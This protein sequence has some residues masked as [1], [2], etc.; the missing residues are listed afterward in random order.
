MLK[1][2]VIASNITNL[3]DARYFAARGVDYLLFDLS[4]IGINEVMAIAE[5]VEG[6]QILVSLSE[7]NAHLVD[8]VI[9]RISP[10]AIGTAEASVLDK[11]LTYAADRKVFFQYEKTHTDPAKIILCDPDSIDS[12]T[13]Q[14]LPDEEVMAFAEIHPTIES[15]NKFL[16]KTDGIGI[17]LKGSS[18]EEVGLKSFEQLDDLLEALEE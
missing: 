9:L 18:E 14:I 13:L 2:S 10:F 17:V 11:V 15:L 5:W 6:L 8:E 7:E 16:E 3:T 4:E 1:R 12:T